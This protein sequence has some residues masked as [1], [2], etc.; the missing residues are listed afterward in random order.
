MASFLVIGDLH[1][2]ISNINETKKL[3]KILVDI[4][5]E[6]EPDRIVILGD[7]LHDFNKVTTQP[8]VESIEF[9]AEMCK[10]APVILLIGNHDLPG[11]TYFLSN[12]HAFTALKYWNN[13]LV[14]DDICKIFEVNSLKFAAVPYVP[15]GM[16][17]EA[18]ESNKNYKDEGTTCIFGHQ[19]FVGCDDNG[20]I[21][22][23]GDEWNESRPLV[24]SGH[25]HQYQWLQKNICYVGTPRQT[26]FGDSPEKTVS[27]FSFSDDGSVKE[28]RI[29]IPL[30]Q[31]LKFR[32]NCSMIDSWD[33]PKEGTIRIE[34]IGTVDE[35]KTVKLHPKLKKWK[36]RGITM[37]YSFTQEEIDYS[38]LRDKITSFAVDR[39]EVTFKSTFLKKIENN[40]EYVKLYKNL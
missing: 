13:I 39:K 35:I 38:K 25:I 14:V 3:R 27:F 36:K 40:P 2:K 9:I 7:T 15:D 37:K 10:L 34:F 1:I 16:F 19:T 17:Q 24:I 21:S 18:L 22:K 11:P 23:T 30:P 20:F 29:K 4:I 28:E 8:L 12:L 32:L 31:K 26:S 6:K 33:P 5:E